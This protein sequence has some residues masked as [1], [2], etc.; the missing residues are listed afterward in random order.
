[1]SRLSVSNKQRTTFDG[2]TETEHDHV[3]VHGR[4]LSVGDPVTD[5]DAP[6][7]ARVMRLIDAR[8]DAFVIDA[9]SGEQTVHDKNPDY[10]RDAAVVGVC[11]EN[12]LAKQDAT[13]RRHADR[14]WAQARSPETDSTP[15]GFAERFIDAHSDELIVYHFPST[16]L[17][18][19]DGRDGGETA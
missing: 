6:N 19:A 7:V 13:Y 17:R 2:T 10:P 4:Q 18:R 12:W 14:V 3:D 9:L 16:R 8:A 15:E 5:D 11:F 1:M